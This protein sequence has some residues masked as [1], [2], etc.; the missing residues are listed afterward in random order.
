MCKDCLVDN[1]LVG[2]SLSVQGLQEGAFRVDAPLT[3]GLYLQEVRKKNDTELPE[4]EGLCGNVLPCE[5][6]TLSTP[7]LQYM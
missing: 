5:Y 3:Q 4:D 1:R 7:S 2:Q 6:L